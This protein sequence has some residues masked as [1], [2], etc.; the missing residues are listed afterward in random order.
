M[1]DD[2]LDSLLVDGSELDRA[3]LAGILLPRA[4]LHLDRG[5]IT[6]RFTEVGDKLTVKE[7]IVVYL[8]A[9][10]AQSLKDLEGQTIEQASPSEIEKATG[11]AG[12]TL[13]PTLRKL[14]DERLLVQD[15][16]GGAYSV[17]NYALNRIKEF[18]PPM[19]KEQM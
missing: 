10:K 18:L 5:K 16:K 7:K 11:I 6:I 15:S 2:P 8:L 1:A 12:G 17:P 14:V 13:R 3:L 9:R 4:R 19:E